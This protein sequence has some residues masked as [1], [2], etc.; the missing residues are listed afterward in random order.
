[1]ALAAAQWRGVGGD[2]EGAQPDDE[3]ST[4]VGGGG[5]EEG[6]RRRTRLGGKRGRLAA[7]NPKQP[8]AN[9]AHGFRKGALVFSQGLGEKGGGAGKD[10]DAASKVSL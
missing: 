4:L 1:M 3:R 6:S 7:A 5:R 9:L 8:A 2:D 10:W